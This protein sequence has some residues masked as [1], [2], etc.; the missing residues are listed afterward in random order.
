[1]DEEKWNF[2]R[3]WKKILEQKVIRNLHEFTK[4]TSQ[5]WVTQKNIDID[6][7]LYGQD[8]S[9]N[10]ESVESESVNL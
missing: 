7:K 10:I 2:N 8:H 3:Y 6:Y 9:T 5:I 4:W 1:M